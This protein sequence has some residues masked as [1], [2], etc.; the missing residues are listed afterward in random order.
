M[1][2]QGVQA[3]HMAVDKPSDKFLGF[4]AKHY[5]LSSKVPQI[6]NFVVY[7]NFFEERPGGFITML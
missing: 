1:Q 7:D 3:G 6:N 2:E 4:L 5:N